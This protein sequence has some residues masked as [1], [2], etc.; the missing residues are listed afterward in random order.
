MSTM[1]DIDSV[2]TALLNREGRPDNFW[3]SW[4]ARRK[5]WVCHLCDCSLSTSIENSSVADYFSSIERHGIN[6]LKEHGLLTYL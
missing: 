3:Y 1:R 4:S 5:E 6:H 2:L